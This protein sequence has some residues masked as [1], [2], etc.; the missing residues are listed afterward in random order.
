M[1]QALVAGQQFIDA[2]DSNDYSEI[3]GTVDL[4]GTW[5]VDTGLDRA[6]GVHGFDPG[7]TRPWP[8]HGQMNMQE[9]T[10]LLKNIRL[11][12][13]D[14]CRQ[15]RWNS[16]AGSHQ[17]IVEVKGDGTTSEG[18]R[19]QNRYAFVLDVENGLVKH[20]REYLD[21]KHAADIFAN[22]K[23]GSPSTYDW[24]VLDT[25][26]SGTSLD[27][28]AIEF[29]QAITEANPDRMKSIAANDATWWADTGTKR[30]IG[31]F[32]RAP[33]GDSKLIGNVNLWRRVEQLPGLTKTFNSGWI[34]HPTR[35][36]SDG[37]SISIEASSNGQRIDPKTSELKTY[38]NRYC[39][40]IETQ[41]K[42]ITK[43]REYCDTQHA[44]DVFRMG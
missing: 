34:L 21:T 29:C 38:Q 22:V 3:I 25:V 12:F 36:V 13:P 14:R 24:K 42:K 31:D 4:G 44:F 8:L 27:A 37:Q 35:I 5:W 41:E 23:M 40:I 28:L 1:S 43:V 20:V 11:R 6:A 9:K 33:T 16:F 15:I 39:F 7:D 17:A 32:D 30:E 19:Y 26:T 18:K 2:L 10:S